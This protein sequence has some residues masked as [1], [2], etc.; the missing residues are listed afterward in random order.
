MQWGERH[1][2]I[3]CGEYRV[4][5][6]GRRRKL[7]PA[8]ND[9]VPHGDRAVAAEPGRTPLDDELQR[10]LVVEPGAVSQ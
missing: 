7:H 8:V 6:P 1:Q 3:E 2:P 4:V 5:D 9:T 10:Q